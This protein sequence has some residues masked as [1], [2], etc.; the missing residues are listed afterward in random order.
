MRR[1]TALPLLAL[2]AILLA[3]PA[4]AVVGRSDTFTGT[5]S[6]VVVSSIASPVKFFAVQVK[7]TGAA[8]TLWDVRVEC[9][10]DNVNFS[11]VLA[12]ATGDGDGIV[13]ASSA[14]LCP[15]FRSRVHALTLAPATNIVVT[16]MGSD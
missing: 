11:Q 4:E 1:F 16:L 14:F 6:G 12:H 10:L 2:F 13:K 7:G 5:A 3:H 15:Y 8:A 9:S